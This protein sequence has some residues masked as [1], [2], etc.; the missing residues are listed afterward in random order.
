MIVINEF[1]DFDPEDEYDADDPVEVR[2]TV[3]EKVVEHLRSHIDED[4]TVA[5]RIDALRLVEVLQQQHVRGVNRRRLKAVYEA[6][7][8]M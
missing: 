1:R 2:L 5:R 4:R 7:R 3:L 6:L 8:D